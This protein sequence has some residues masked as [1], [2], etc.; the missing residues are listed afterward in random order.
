MTLRAR[1]TLA[2]VVVVFVPITI[3]A[4]LV[5]VRS[6]PAL[7]LTGLL[8]TLI[9]VVAAGLALSIALGWLV[10]RITTRPL[11][12]LTDAAKRVAGGELDTRIAV[13]SADEV[14]QLGAVFNDMTG[15]LRRTISELTASRDQM[16]ASLSRLGDTLSSTLDLKRT[17]DVIMETAMTSAR[18]QAGALLLHAPTRGDLYLATAR[19][20]DARGVSRSLRVPVGEGIIGRVAASGD[21]ALG[22]TSDLAQLRQPGAP[23]LAGL[24]AAPSEPDAD[25]V[26]AVALRSDNH[27]LGVLALY[28]R[29]DGVF[30]GGDLDTI[31]SFAGQAAIAIDNVLRA[32]DAQRASITDG[33][34]GL[35]NHR[36]FQLALAKETERAARFG[37]PLSLLMLDL[38]HF[39]QVNDEHGHPRGDGVLV[40]TAGRLRDELREVDTIARYGGEELVVILP[41]TDLAG[42]QIVAER[43]CAAVRDTPYGDADEEPL[44]ITV[45]AGIAAFP[46]HGATVGVLV[47]NADEAM[48]AAKRAGRDRWRAARPAGG[49]IPAQPSLPGEPGPR[50]E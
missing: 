45:S 4:I 40:E 1:L 21:P 41:E 10:A 27:T 3:G 50:T 20:L 36:Y 43:I 33:L 7:D 29:R 48:Y 23:T 12:E 35:W 16:R 17:L 22:R 19:G 5:G 25:N 18:A 28:D 37:R 39:K 44:T 42:A 24:R 49:T 47:R 6:S 2:F 9:P 13:R 15:E 30:D 26:L 11:S 31:Q 32:Q 34:T 46:E 8:I 38:D 14:G